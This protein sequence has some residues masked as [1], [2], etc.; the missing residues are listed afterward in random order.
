MLWSRASMRI[1]SPLL[2]AGNPTISQLFQQSTQTAHYPSSTSICRTINNAYLTQR[3]HETILLKRTIMLTTN[4]ILG[5]TWR[6][7]KKAYISGCNRECYK[8]PVFRWLRCQMRDEKA[9]CTQYRLVCLI[10][11]YGDHCLSPSLF[12]PK[13]L[14]HG[15][16][17]SPCPQLFHTSLFVWFLRKWRTH[18]KITRSKTYFKRSIQRKCSALRDGRSP[19]VQDQCTNNWE[20]VIVQVIVEHL[21]ED[22]GRCHS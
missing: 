11:A 17:C 21:N 10:T 1:R 15:L 18:L 14:H 3:P 20:L 6:I 2:D 4:L 8:F 12:L 5:H 13:R 7:R 9:F 19:V 22:R 16:H